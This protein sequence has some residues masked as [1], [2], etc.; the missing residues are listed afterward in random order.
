MPHALRSLLGPAAVLALL[1]GCVQ[2]PAAPAASALAA[3]V[4]PAYLLAPNEWSRTVADSTDAAG[5]HVM[6]TEYAAGLY[7]QPDGT[8]ASVASVTI[9]TLI[10]AAAGG[11]SRGA[12]ITST[13]VGLATT[14]GWAANVKKPGG[15]DK[16]IGVELA[17]R[18]TGQKA[19]FSFL[20]LAG[21]T[22]IDAGA[23]R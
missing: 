8:S 4:T 9:Q 19:V 18:A 2:D 23:V 10:P 11:S 16:E 20:Y 17:N 15:C 12:C 21:K 6:V 22:R 1:T 3:T 14:S 7:T 13:I 5:T